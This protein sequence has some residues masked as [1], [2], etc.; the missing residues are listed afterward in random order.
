MPATAVSAPAAPAP[1]QVQAVSS[2]PAAIQGATARCQD[3]EYSSSRHRQG[4]CSGHGGVAQ[5]L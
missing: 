2:V 3:G 1:A 4:T 5:W